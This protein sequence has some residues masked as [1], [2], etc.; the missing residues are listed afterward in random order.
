[1]KKAAAHHESA[2]DRSMCKSTFAFL[3]LGNTR[4]LSRNRDVLL[5]LVACCGV[6]DKKSYIIWSPWI[7]AAAPTT[8]AKVEFW[9]STTSTRPCVHQGSHKI[10]R[11]LLAAHVKAY[12]STPTSSTRVQLH[13]APRLLVT[14]PHG[15]YVNLAVRRDYSSPAARAPCQPC[16]ALQV[17]VSRLQRL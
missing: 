8:R 14:R 15:L 17:L 4:S 2:W 7:E 1:L 9:S 5:L 12:V 3:I 10:S 6:L 16:R 13:S 11:P